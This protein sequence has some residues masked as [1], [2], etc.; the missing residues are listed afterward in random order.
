MTCEYCNSNPS[1]HVLHGHE[2]CD[3]CLDNMQKEPSEP[4]DDASDYIDHHSV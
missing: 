2:V 1:T 4:D 3:E